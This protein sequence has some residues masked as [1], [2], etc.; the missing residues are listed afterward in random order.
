MADQLNIANRA[1]LAVGARGQISSLNPSDGSVEGDHISTLWQPTFEQLARTAHWN[2]LGIQV[3]LPLLAAAMGTPENPDGLTLPVPPTPWLYAYSYPSDCLDVRYIVPSY[4]ASTGLSTPAFPVN[5]AA[6]SWLP[7]GGQISFK[8]Q[9]VTLA[10]ATTLL[11]ILTN[12]QLAQ[13]VYTVNDSNPAG[14]DS[15]FQEAMVATLGAFLVPALSLDIPLMDR[16]VK[17]AEMAIAQA[18]IRDG[19]EGVTNMD[20]SPDW[21][22]ARYGGQGYNLGFGYG[23]G[24]NSG[25][26][27]SM[28]WPGGGSF[29]D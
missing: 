24:F 22:Q 28:S 6:A 11:T 7:T 2:C 10:P 8:V 12:Q 27:Y 29:G 19:N 18:R 1:L 5:V 21:M 15:L 14:W 25:A 9:K 16:C 3:T 20:H 4:P 23:N 26:G 13:A 17:Q